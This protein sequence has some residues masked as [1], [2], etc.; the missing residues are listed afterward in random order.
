MK[1]HT[2]QTLR[3]AGML[4]LAVMTAAAVW[5]CSDSTTSPTVSIL[6]VTGASPASSGATSQLTATATLS[7][8]A[9]QDVTSSSTWTSSNTSIAT[10]SASG[11]VT[12]VASGTVV[13]QATYNGVTGSE[14][15]VIP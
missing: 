3:A 7:S 11:L 10:V 15:L 5:A 1:Q 13:I 14:S 9:T 4:L 2:R 6:A 12:A 8:S